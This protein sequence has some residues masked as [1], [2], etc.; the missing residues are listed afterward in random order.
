VCGP[1]D[2]IF[3]AN[4]K[5]IP[6]QKDGLFERVSEGARLILKI[7]ICQGQDSES[8]PVAPICANSTHRGGDVGA[9]IYPHHSHKV[10][11]LCD[12]ECGFVLHGPKFIRSIA[13]QKE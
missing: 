4:K 13:S 12:D 11:N 8:T 3:S 7:S 5:N 6:C 9:D 1:Y 10:Y 2:I